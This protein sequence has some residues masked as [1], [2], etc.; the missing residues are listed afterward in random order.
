MLDRDLVAE[1]SA[2]LIRA[3]APGIF[4]EALGKGITE[5]LPHNLSV[6]RRLSHIVAL[7]REEAPQALGESW[8]MHMG[9]AL[10]CAIQRLQHEHGRAPSRWAWGRVRPM[11]LTHT[12]GKKAPMDRLFHPA[13]VACGGDASTIAQAA[14]DLAHPDQNP[15]GVPTLR[16]VIDVGAW[17]NSRFVLIHGQSGNPY[18]PHYTDQLPLW[19]RGDG[20]PIAWSEDD[21]QRTTRHTLELTP[22]PARGRW[23]RKKA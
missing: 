9:R 10:D 6:T 15:V 22:K 7:T 16:T 17:Q 4:D 20:I 8:P 11:Q 12:F 18:S 23:S 1:L 19:Q 3:H 21:I 13:P 5:L 2:E 14:V